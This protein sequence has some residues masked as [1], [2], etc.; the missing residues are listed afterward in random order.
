MED[1]AMCGYFF[2]TIG[3]IAAMGL[4]GEYNWPAV[5]NLHQASN[6]VFDFFLN[7][8]WC[9]LRDSESWH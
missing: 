9:V 1:S 6:T 3:V 2:G 5:L 4:S 7:S 8:L